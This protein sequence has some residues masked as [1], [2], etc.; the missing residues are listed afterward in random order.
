VIALTVKWLN[1]YHLLAVVIGDDRFEVID[2]GEPPMPAHPPMGAEAAHADPAMRREL[3]PERCRLFAAMFV[4]TE[5]MESQGVH[6]PRGVL[7]AGSISKARRAAVDSVV[8]EAGL[9]VVDSCLRRPGRNRASGDRSRHAR[10]EAAV[11]RPELRSRFT[12]TLLLE[13]LDDEARGRRLRELLAGKPLVFEPSSEP[14]RLLELCAGTTEEQLLRF[15]EDAVRRAA[16]RAVDCGTPDQISVTL[17]DFEFKELRL[18][19]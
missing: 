7:V 4:H 17:A 1:A 3:G 15:V 13:E 14:E 2:C 5:I 19:G 6:V 10:A 16:L 8:E 9:P 18:A 11:R 12:E